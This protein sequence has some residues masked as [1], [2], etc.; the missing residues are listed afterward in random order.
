M[1]RRTREY[2]SGRFGDYYR[3]VDPT[4]PPDPERREWGHIPWT[5]GAAT[6]M[7]RHQS[8]YDL[9]E[10]PDFLEREAPRHVYFSAARYDD[11]GAAEMDAKGW[12]GAD[13]VFDLDADHLPSV[14]PEAATYAEMLAACKDALRRL[15]DLLEDDFGFE[16]V[17]VVFSGGRGYHVHVRDEGLAGLDSAARREVVD[18][19]RAVDLD[20]EGLVRTRAVDGVTRRELRTE[21]GWGRRTHRRLREFVEELRTLDEDEATDRLTAFDGIGEKGAATLLDA[22]VDNDRAVERGNVEVGGPGARTL[23]EALATETVAAETAPIDEPVTTDTHRLIRLPG[24]L[25]GGSG[26]VVRRIDR[27]AVDDFDP[28]VDAVPE[29]FT[30]RSVRVDVTDPGRVELDGDTFTLDAGEQTVPECVGV[31]LMTRD[32]AR[33][34]KE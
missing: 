33:K 27:D 32:R 8:I 30:R 29:R 20:V 17:T 25:H 28:L 7:V 21:G 18:Y 12:Q 24:S 3:G 4:L 14:D 6:T 31:F 19:V 11:P 23:V 13:L 22:F 9:G 1:D 26:L 10:V 15:L 16:D 5:D 34:V 2:L